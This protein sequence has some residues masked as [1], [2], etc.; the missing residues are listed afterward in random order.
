M[1]ASWATALCHTSEAY[2]QHVY[3]FNL[4]PI[5]YLAQERL[6]HFVG[7]LPE[8]LL[9]SSRARR[10]LSLFLAGAN[11]LGQDENRL[12][13]FWDF[14]K[15]HR[16]LALLGPLILPSLLLHVGLA[17]CNRQV[18]GLIRREQVLELRKNIG[19]KAYEFV[20]KRA[21]F[22]VGSEATLFQEAPGQDPYNASLLAGKRCFEAA[23]S[24]EPEALLNRVALL[25]PPDSAPQPDPHDNATKDRA[26]GLIHK[27]LAKE[28]A[29]QWASIIS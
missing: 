29:P 22:I 8:K 15:P 16:R 19:A 26:F 2:V 10:S 24:G 4:R 3:R 9:Q 25:F 18:A 17:L 23:L 21:P 12:Q 20:L 13:Q 27:I 5:D 1:S 7:K 28:V 14:S 11:S 6:E